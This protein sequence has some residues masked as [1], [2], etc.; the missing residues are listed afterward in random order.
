MAMARPKNAPGTLP[1]ESALLDFLAGDKGNPAKRDIARAFGLKGEARAALRLML[2]DMEARGLIHRAGK[3]LANPNHLP[4]VAMLEVLGQDRHGELYGEPTEWDERRL[5]KAPKV[6]IEA[7]PGRGEGT[8]PPGKGERVLAK[9]EKAAG[10]YPIRAKVMRSFAT[11]GRRVLGVVRHV[12]GHGLRLQPVDK[13]ARNE[14]QIPPGADGGARTGELVLAEMDARGRG[15][16][17]ARVKERLGDMSDPRNISLIAIHAHAIPNV[18]PDRVMAEAEALKPFSRGGRADFSKLPLITIDPADARDHDD[19]V[20]AAPDDDPQNEGGFRVVVAIA[21]VAAYVRPATAL[22]R[23]ARARGNSVYFPDRVVPMLPERL[24]NDLC[25]LKEGVERPALA[26]TMQFN[27]HGEKKAHRFQ[28]ITMRSAAKLSY[29]EAQAAID[30]QASDRAGPLVDGVLKPLWAAWRCVTEAR[31]K[32]SPLELDLPER[33]IILDQAGRVSRVVVPPRLDA[34]RLIEEFM[35]LA[36]VAAAEELEARKTPLLYRVHD[37]PSD[38]KIRALAEFLKTVNQ[39]LPLGQVMRPRHFNDLLSRVAGEEYQHQVHEIVLRTQAQ[40][41]YAPENRGHFGLALRRYAHFTSPIRRYA[42]LIVHRALVSALG[43]GDDGL[44]VEDISQLAETGEM[45]S[46]AERRAMAA[47]RETNDR[48]IASYLAGREGAEF[49]GRI[50]G[51]VGAGL[52]IKLDDTGADGFVPVSSLGTDYFIY[53]GVRHA[54]SGQRSGETYQLGDRVTV[55]LLE[56]T[57]LQGGLRFEMVS[58]GR[59]GAPARIRRRTTPR[60]RR[61]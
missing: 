37:E 23:E 33:K 2:K 45:I 3:R 61:R 4:P 13:K 53:D 48:L 55:R 15:L 50:G 19:A 54:L 34:H 40:A 56:V 59:K 6:L 5:G 43:L 38:D 31:D 44:S 36:N 7:P 10:P 42:D 29:E 1:S 17:T 30:G 25:S 51:V 47:E 12:K 22:D 49:A 14:F 20:W 32:R 9:I 8:R 39:T 26:V 24:S 58:E 41:I 52:F 21:D 28:R 46:D 18:F 35:I 60:P 57:P 27:R 16:P 11:G